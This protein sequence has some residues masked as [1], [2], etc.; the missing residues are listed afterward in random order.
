MSV[1]EASPMSATEASPMYVTEASPMS[2]TEASPASMLQKC[3]VCLCYRNF[4]CVCG[5]ETSHMSVLQKRHLCLYY[6]NVT[7]V[8]VTET[9]PMSVLQKPHLGAA[10]VEDFDLCR[11][12]LVHDVSRHIVTVGQVPQQSQH[13][14]HTGHFDN[15]RSHHKHFLIQHTSGLTQF[16]TYTSRINTSQ[17]TLHPQMSKLNTH[18]NSHTTRPTQLLTNKLPKRTQHFSMTHH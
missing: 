6:R 13:L 9:S 18:L 10:E 1:T 16:S 7:C 17:L 4:T 8:C 15:T 14:G 3:H 11:Q 2:A 12:G 5:I